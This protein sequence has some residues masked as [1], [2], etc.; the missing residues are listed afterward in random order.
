MDEMEPLPEDLV[1]DDP[2]RPWKALVGVISAIVTYLITQTV[3]EFPDWVELLLNAA[4]VGLAVYAIPNP[5]VT[6]ES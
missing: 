4:A 3:L 5:K 6:T 1:K 2:V